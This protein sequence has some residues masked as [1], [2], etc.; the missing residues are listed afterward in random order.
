M[1]PIYKLL[2]IGAVAAGCGASASAQNTTRL[3]VTKA[4]DYALVYTLP[5]TNLSVTLEAEIT[6]K[7]PGEFYKYA[8]KYL[9]INDPVTKESRTATLKSAV[10]STFG[11]PDADQRYAVQFKSGTDAY[12]ML[13]SA[14]VPLAVNTTKVAPAETVTLPEA[15]PAPPTP[16][17]TPAARQ[18]VSEER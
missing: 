8:K 9:N 5:V 6:V 10:V 12:M 4:N 1:N 14:N 7:K 2:L 18:V 3:S 16:L 17:E 13:S 11:L 15:Q